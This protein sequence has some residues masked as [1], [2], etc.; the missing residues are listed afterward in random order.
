MKN[1]KKIYEGLKIDSKDLGSLSAHNLSNDFIIKRIYFIYQVKKNKKR[2]FHAHLK[3][4]QIAW[5]TCGSI[6]ITLD[7]G[8]NKE[9]FILEE[10]NRA[11]LID[12]G[13][14][15]EMEWLIKD[16]VMCIAASDFYTE[17]D[18]IRSYDDFIKLAEKGF[19]D[20]EK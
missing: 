3:L 7:N 19:W 1:I 12:S 9:S 17:D 10:P 4:K 14:W 15:H 8:F 20:D 5:V 18:Y 13:V 16:S 2:G 6:K 11:I